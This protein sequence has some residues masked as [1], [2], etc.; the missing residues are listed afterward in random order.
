MLRALALTLC[1]LAG[2]V[3]AAPCRQALALGLDVSGSV[4]AREY[5]LQ[6][7]GLA[8]ALLS[9][10]V[11]EAVTLG[12]VAE[13]RVMVFEWSGPEAQRVVLPWR[14]VRSE[15]DLASLSA[16]LRSVTRVPM[17]ESTA[18]GSALRFAQAALAEQS[19]CWQLTLDLSGD[20]LSNTGPHP[21]DVTRAGLG[22]ITVNG[23]VIGQDD[24]PAGDIRQTGLA[25]LSAYYRA[26]V[27]HGPDPFVETALGFEDYARAMEAKLLRELSTLAVGAVDTG[28]IPRPDL[29]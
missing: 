16:Q 27:L 14:A 24:A 26:Y 23:L 19:A 12:P 2:A 15:A 28:L 6:L 10:R 5:R 17:D 9:P 1:A 3:E 29:R 7:D 21:R 25:E 20:G 4:D 18:I 8:A 11:V 22:R 13:L